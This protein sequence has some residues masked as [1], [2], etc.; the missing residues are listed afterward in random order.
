MSEVAVEAIILAI[1]ARSRHPALRLGPSAEDHEW[2]LQFEKFAH[3]PGRI[4]MSHPF[5]VTIATIPV[6]AV[7][8]V[9]FGFS[10]WRFTAGIVVWMIGSS[11]TKV[12]NLPIYNWR[13]DGKNTDS[14]E[15]KKS[16]A[17]SRPAMPGAQGS[18]SFPLS[19]WHVSSS[20]RRQQLPSPQSPSSL[21]LA[22]AR[23]QIQLGHELI[24]GFPRRTDPPRRRLPVQDCYGRNTIQQN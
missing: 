6:F 17:R 4:A 5:A 21:P 11:V 22:L 8:C 14:E 23:P 9:A 7:V 1:N 13:K 15:L 3:A 12:V 10:L 20:S 19:P 18:R 16:G 24:K 2:N